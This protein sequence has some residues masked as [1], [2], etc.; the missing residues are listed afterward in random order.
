MIPVRAVQISVTEHRVGICQLKP[1]RYN[2]QMDLQSPIKEIF[3]QHMEIY[4]LEEKHSK[5]YWCAYFLSGTYLVGQSELQ[6]LLTTFLSPFGSGIR[7]CKARQ[8]FLRMQQD[9]DVTD[10]PGPL[11]CPTLLW[12]NLA[13]VISNC[14]LNLTLLRNLSLCFNKILQTFDPWRRGRGEKMEE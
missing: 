3:M 4:E 14:L 6:R 11:S 12:L 1:S 7:L 5:K 8:I 13:Q 2:Y 10:A 9:P